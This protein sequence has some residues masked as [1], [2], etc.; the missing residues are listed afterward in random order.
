MT[1]GVKRE[2]PNSAPALPA[3]ASAAGAP[4]AN[5]LITVSVY[6]KPQSP[7]AGRVDL[8]T[9]AQRRA[10]DHA[11]DVQALRDFAA[12]HGLT[13]EAV[14]PAR[15]LVKLSGTAAQI[16]SAFAVELRSYQAE[17][18]TFRS[19]AGNVQVPEGLAD[20]V[21]AVLGLDTRPIAQPRRKL[22]P[23][24]PASHLPNQVGALYGFPKDVTGQGQCIALIELGGGYLASDN[25]AAFKAMGLSTPTIVAVSVDGA[26]DSPG[27]DADGEVA[28]DIQVAGGNAPGARIAV[29]FAPNTVQGFVDAITHAATD[30]TNQPKVI[31]ISWGTAEVNWAATGMQAMNAMNS[32]LQDA[33]NLGVSTFVAAGDNLG[34]DGVNNGR[35]NVDFP[36]SSPWAIGCGGTQIS[37]SSGKIVSE[38]V[39]NEGPSGWGTGGGISD[40]FSVPAFQSKTTLPASVNGGRHG[41]GVPDVAGDASGMSPYSIVLDGA[42]NQIGGTSAVAPLWAA[43]TALLNQ[44]CGTSLGFFLPTLY[45]SP[46][47]MREITVGNNKPIG[48]NLG[49]NAGPHWNAC[50][51]LGVPTATIESYFKTA[52]A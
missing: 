1:N 18:K 13:V 19:H 29:Y 41:R 6:L 47:P 39:W 8:P 32:A 28:L 36:A 4:S 17:G 9:L 30:T 14:E 3:A 37:T 44:A 34:T 23:A 52:T 12:Q 48:T 43:L 2:L 21:E 51:G 45:A 31:S 22:T 24:A 20:R 7:A 46:T 26:T 49:Y 50:T 10:S 42:V 5:E 33:A 15:R 38:V 25:Q 11:D 27:S 40:Y 35:A 16:Q